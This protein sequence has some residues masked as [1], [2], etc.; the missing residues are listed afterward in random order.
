MMKTCMAELQAIKAA[1]GAS[2]MAD[3][4][5]TPAPETP[6]AAAPA[7]APAATAPVN[8]LATAPVA[9]MSDKDIDRRIAAA[10]ARREAEREV[11]EWLSANT[12]GIT[13]EKLVSLA[14]S[15]RET[16]KVVTM[17]GTPKP[18]ATQ[19][20]SVGGAKGL[21]PL[22]QL[23]SREYAVQMREKH[24]KN[25]VFDAKAYADEYKRIRAPYT[26]SSRQGAA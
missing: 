9:T 25:G 11:D 12:V 3:P 10:L 22:E 5:S 1:Q 26:L 7:A 13:R 15:D 2:P 21:S 24:T 17:S 18:G 16:Y 20:Q 6:P 19:R 23:T 8:P 14:M 4:A